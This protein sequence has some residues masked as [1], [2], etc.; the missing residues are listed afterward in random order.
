[1]GLTPRNPPKKRFQFKVHAQRNP[2]DQ[3]EHALFVAKLNQQFGLIAD[4]LTKNSGA[5]PADAVTQ[6]DLTAAINALR[7]E[8][9][10][11]PP[12]TNTEPETGQSPD[13]PVIGVVE[14]TQPTS[15]PP[16]IARASSIGT[17]IDPLQFSYADHTHGDRLADSLLFSQKI[18]VT[19][20][21]PVAGTYGDST[22]VPVLIVDNTGR[23]QSVTNVAITATS[24][25]LLYRHTLGFPPKGEVTSK[26]PVQGTYGSSTL[27]PVISVD[28]IGRVT[29]ITTAS[30]S[31]TA[32]TLLRR[33]FMTAHGETTSKRPVAGSYGSASAVPVITVDHIGRVTAVTTSAISAS[34]PGFRRSL[35]LGGM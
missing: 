5:A 4:E 15:P 31:A 20:K 12:E 26:R 9:T 17:T 10:P 14:G 24:S 34:D 8:L 23:V 32:D 7:N 2:A 6:D 3:A 30:V 25:D 35:L 13:E 1:M 22:H 27:V 11:P 33:T 19:S 18:Q 28:H 21:R 16:N 29:N